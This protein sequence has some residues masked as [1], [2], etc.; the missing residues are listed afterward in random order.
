MTTMNAPTVRTTRT[1]T[2]A[3]FDQ[4]AVLA[5]LFDSLSEK[6]AVRLNH[7]QVDIV[8]SDQ[9]SRGHFWCNSAVI[10]ACF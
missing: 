9:Q 4:L 3:Q 6:N 2:L 10:M 5:S 7:M 8:P 1:L